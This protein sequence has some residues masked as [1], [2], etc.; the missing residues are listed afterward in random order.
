ML[1]VGNHAGGNLLARILAV[2]ML[3]GLSGHAFGLSPAEALPAF[4][5]G[6]FTDAAGT[7]IMYR[8]LPPLNYDPTRRYPLFVWLHGAGE[9]GHDNRLQINHGAEVF[10]DGDLRAR[11][12]AF[13]LVPQCPEGDRWTNMNSK[14]PAGRQHL[15]PEPTAAASATFALVES[16]EKTYSI[17]ATDVTLLGISMGGFGVWDWI[18][19]RPDLFRAAVPMSGGG[20]ADRIVR[21]AGLRILAVHGDR[22]DTVALAQSQVMVAALRNVGARPE[23]DVVPNCGHGDW[24]FVMQDPRV[25][26]WL[27]NRAGDR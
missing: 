14:T 2:F 26:D 21:A 12:P 24:E 5:A 18:T 3:C 25:Q 15:S 16:L 17:D 8:L 1:R 10:A 20:D 7:R 4:H 27:F 6:E 11:H 23:F 13:V 22:D 9:V 19:R